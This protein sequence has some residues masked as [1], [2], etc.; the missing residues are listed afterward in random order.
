MR[1]QAPA[2]VIREE[3]SAER[4]APRGLVRIGITAILLLAVLPVAFLPP[5]ADVRASNPTFEP[6]V[7]VDDSPAVVGTPDIAAAR[8]ASLHV[9]WADRRAG[10][11]NDDIYYSRSV[12]SGTTW[13][14]SV[15]VD[16]EPTGRRAWNPVVAVSRDTPPCVYV[17]WRQQTLLG[18]EIQS[19]ASPD[20]G[21]SWDP[22][23]R[24]DGGPSN[25]SAFYPS[26]AVDDGGK[27][28][29]A[30]EDRRNYADPYQVFFSVS[31]DRG[32][33]WAPSLQVSAADYTTSG[34][35]AL[36]PTVA[37]S[38]AD[39]VAI[40]WDYEST[41]RFGVQ[42][43]FSPD[44]GSSWAR[45]TARLVDLGVGSVTG[46]DLTAAPDGEL[47]LMWKEVASSPTLTSVQFSRS[48]AG[49]AAWSAPVRVDDANPTPNANPGAPSVAAAAGRIYGVWADTRLPGDAGVYAS[50]SDDS[51][52]TWGDGIANT[53]SRVDDDLSPADQLYPSTAGGLF[54]LY[55]VWEDGRNNATDHDIYF[56]R[57]VVS[58]VLITEIRDAPDVEEY[59]EIVNFGG[60]DRDITGWTLVIDASTTID[61]SALG[62]VPAMAHRTIGRPGSGADLTHALFALPN[63]GGTL[64]LS[65]PGGVVDS[66]G[67][68]QRGVAPD[69]LPA[70]GESTARCYGNTGYR[71]Q[72]AG[73]PTGTPKAANDGP[74]VDTAPTLVLNEVHFT[75]TNPANR[76]IELF[77]LG[78]VPLNVGGHTLAVNGAY[79]ILGGFTLTPANPFYFVTP[80]S[81]PALF[82]ALLTGG[83]NVYLYGPSGVLLDM[84]GWDTP[85]VIDT[86][87]CRVPNGFG[88]HQAFNDTTAAS[89]GWQSGC[90]PSLPVVTIASPQTVYSELGKTVRF[91]LTV[92]NRG[93]DPDVI[94]VTNTSAPNGWPVRTLN[95][96]GTAPLLDTDLDGVPDTGPL[97]WQQTAMITLLVS[98]PTTTP[99]APNEFID[100]TARS[101]TYA[102]G[103]DTARL[104]IL[105][106]SYLATDRT[107]VPSTVDLLGTGGQEY[108]TMTLTTTALGNPYPRPVTQD[109]VL[110]IDSSGSMGGNDPRNDRLTAA[111]YYIDQLSVPDRVSIVD[112]DSICTWTGPDHHLDS[113][114]HD[115]LPD[116]ADPK[117][118]VDTIDSNGGT[119]ILCAV[120]SLNQEFVSRGDPTH[121][122]MGILLTDGDG[123]DPNL[124][125]QEANVSALLNI[126]VFTIGL[127]GGPN[128]GLLQGIADETGGQ[129]YPAPDPSYLLSIYQSIH[130]AMANVTAIDPRSLSLPYSMIEEHLPP[131]VQAVAGSFTLPPGSIET[132][133]DPDYV[134]AGGSIL[135][136][137]VSQVRLGETWSISYLVT[138]SLPGTHPVSA[139]PDA[140]VAYVNWN[141]TLILT[142]FPDRPI[143]CVGPPIS[144]P[145]N[146][147]TRWIGGVGNPVQVSWTPPAILPDHY[148]IY[149]V[150]GDPRGFT[151]FSPAAAVRSVGGSTTSW[152]DNLPAGP[153]QYYYL[154]RASDA[155]QLVLSPTTNTAGVYL[156]TLATGRTLVSRPLEYFPWVDYSGSEA[157]TVGEYRTLFGASEVLYLA[158][159]TPWLPV[160]GAGDAAHVLPVGEAMIVVR[161]SPGLFVFTGLP[162]SM[163][164]FDEDA[165]AGYDPAAA[166]VRS[167]TATVVGDSVRLQFVRP[168][169]MS[170]GVGAYQVYYATSRA[171]LFASGTALGVTDLSPTVTV[172][173]ANALALF[174]ELYYWVVPVDGSPGASSYSVGVWS[175][176][177]SG[178]HAI[179]LPLA[180][181]FPSRT[182][183]WYAADIP[184]TLGILWMNGA[185]EWI[186]HFAP[187]PVGVYDAPFMLAS[188]AELAVTG[189]PGVRY[190]F[191]GY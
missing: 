36:R 160:P 177:Y 73:D 157:D 89:S 108:A 176:T 18:N 109:V 183:A 107:L 40:S 49:G 50:G 48:T 119:D 122:W 179:G 96:A 23:V 121:V 123:G 112:F 174:P 104:T 178:S 182:V 131:Y 117:A 79:T 175:A 16:T 14:P 124:I 62:V 167:L 106:Y 25:V 60:L 168:P 7:L 158:T 181:F 151:D 63:Q 43:A 156:G 10:G 187:M 32:A 86:S 68:G 78:S 74:C 185:G 81:A 140:R 111:K 159:A 64:A 127:G 116:Y 161:S 26:V 82:S 113:P 24:V 153:G 170:A 95:A 65:D 146:V 5:S 105:L 67:Y 98:V 189:P 13:G 110:M 71:N 33:S 47:D 51:G 46:S 76:F 133:P 142:P 135:Q 1:V 88:T 9:V 180:P 136:W 186:P 41:T 54:G 35:R 31:T 141:S 34:E 30:W 39:R 97:N 22:V 150:A 91:Q 169:S 190:A 184:R 37:A 143:T 4:S 188:G 44:A 80:A 84:V 12:D 147:T 21:V 56:A 45:Y 8:D 61:L 11:F 171:G 115:G 17:L 172:V 59:V 42:V 166:G 101:S 120:Q 145:T 28:Y 15:R 83:D 102:L 173:H 103:A 114:G 87:L 125:L 93:I 191:V 138:C 6:N 137:N 126:T 163:I 53:D 92:R 128:V 55:A 2:G 77:Y 38:V 100:V 148:L 162:G 164:R 165:Y 52:Q 149:R 72:W 70:A 85:K 58:E 130:D 19:R 139:Y 3:R 154:L 57:F 75:A 152:T 29:A 155:S 94:D 134:L 66:V 129:Y 27:V 132:V 144:P 69:P 99:A 20:G 118:D 90:A